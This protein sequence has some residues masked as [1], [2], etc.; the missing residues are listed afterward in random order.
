[1]NGECQ[2]AGQLEMETFVSEVSN[3]LVDL[4]CCVNLIVSVITLLSLS[5]V[6]CRLVQSE[7]EQ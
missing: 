5:T 7:L 1:M 2:L 6:S 3:D 4:I